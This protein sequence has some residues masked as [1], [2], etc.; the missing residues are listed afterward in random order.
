MERN[1]LED[2]EVSLIKGMLRLRRRGFTSQDMVSYF[3]TPQR[4]I[5]GGRISEIKNKTNPAYNGIPEARLSV[6]REFMDGYPHQ[7]ARDYLEEWGSRLGGFG[8]LAAGR[9]VE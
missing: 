5:N 9:S 1:R 3:S 6:V 8:L 2:W 4:S 7:P